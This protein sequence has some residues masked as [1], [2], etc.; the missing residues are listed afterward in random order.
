VSFDLFLK[1]GENFVWQDQVIFFVLVIS[2]TSIKNF[3]YKDSKF[4]FIFSLASAVV[5][6]L[7][8]NFNT[9]N[10]SWTRVATNGLYY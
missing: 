2:Q 6:L 8:V 10:M 5:D 4:V 9:G 1:V 7:L 3:N